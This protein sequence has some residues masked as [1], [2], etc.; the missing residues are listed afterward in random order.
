MD[1]SR[2][3]PGRD[4]QITL[5]RDN[6]SYPGF[7]FRNVACNGEIWTGQ[8]SDTRHLFPPV[9]EIDPHQLPNEN[10]CSCV[11]VMQYG[12]FSYFT[13]GDIT[14][15]VE[16]GKPDWFDVE[17]P[18]AD[19]VGAVYVAILNHHG[20]RDTH[21]EHYVATMQ[22][23]VWIGHSWSADHPGQGV[24]N[25][26]ASTYLYPGERDLFATNMMEA[27]RAVIGPRLDRTYRSTQGHIVVRVAP[28]GGQYRVVILDDSAETSV[29]KDVLEYETMREVNR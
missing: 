22:P 12:D 28:G 16:M 25:R 21:N 17:S 26:I 3:A 2:F 10:T 6:R 1:V 4:D 13:G 19:A 14:G 9:S 8:G 5:L 29:V 18:V 27:N 11:G 7:R 15:I 23:R 24:F 20:H